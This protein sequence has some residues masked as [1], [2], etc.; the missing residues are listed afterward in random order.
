V[1]ASVALRGLSQRQAP[2]RVFETAVRARPYVLCSGVRRLRVRTRLIQCK[3]RL[4]SARD[5]PRT[6]ERQGTAV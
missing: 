2:K 4:N 6:E 5:C 1:Y 3:L